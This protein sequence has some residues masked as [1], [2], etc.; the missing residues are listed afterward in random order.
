MIVLALLSRVCDAQRHILT[1]V[2][3]HEHHPRAP[4]TP[5]TGPKD[6]IHGQ[7]HN[8]GRSARASNSFFHGSASSRQNDDSPNLT[9][10]MTSSSTWRTNWKVCGMRSDRSFR[11]HIA[12]RCSRYRQA[13]HVCDVAELEDNED[14][15]FSLLSEM[16]FEP[17]PG[18]RYRIFHLMKFELVE[19]R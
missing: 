8:S 3:P 2:H 11:L 15:H 4:R 9:E 13:L 12:G 1:F 19:L 10:N 6:T 14:P 18:L 17:K 7:F 16:R 5:S